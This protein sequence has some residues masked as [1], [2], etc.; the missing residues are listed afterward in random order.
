MKKRISTRRLLLIVL[1]G[2]VIGAGGI[3][4]IFVHDAYGLETFAQRQHELRY[5][6]RCGYKEW[7]R[8]TRVSGFHTYS[9]APLAGQKKNFA[10]IDQSACQ[11]IFFSIGVNDATFDLTDFQVIRSTVGTLSNDSLFEKPILVEV[12]RTLEKENT[13]T[14]AMNV[15]LQLI[16]VPKYRSPLSTTIWLKL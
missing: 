10:G 11:H 15:F 3:I 6:G 9:H 12:Y 2:L 14:D 1:V 13:P 4:G 7:S 16:F 5:C 8:L